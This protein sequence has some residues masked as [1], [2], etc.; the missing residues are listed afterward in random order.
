MRA[1]FDLRCARTAIKQSFGERRC[2]VVERR[3][4]DFHA[5]QAAHHGLV[6]VQQLQRALARFR[7]IRR[8]GAVELATRDDRPDRGGNVML[9]SAGAQEVQRAT[10]PARA[11]AA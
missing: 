9:I 8:V 6:F 2:A 10:V 1:D 5:R 4:R 7:L 11:R 3:I